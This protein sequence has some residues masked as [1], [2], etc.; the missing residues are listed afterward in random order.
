MK[1]PS[2]S[3]AVPP[4]LP[5]VI[6]ASVLIQLRPAPPRS[7]WKPEILPAVTWIVVPPIPGVNDVLPEWTTATSNAMLGKQPINEALPA[8]AEKANKILA[9]NQKKYG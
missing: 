6:E 3:T 5:C 9:A 2:S 8:A 1:R 7:P 4:E